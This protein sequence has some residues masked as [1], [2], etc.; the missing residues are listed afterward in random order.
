M[1]DA[2]LIVADRLT[3]R[4]GATLAVDQ[5]SLQ[6]PPGSIT[7]LLGPNGA[8]KT[9]TL[10]MLL[11]LQPPESGSACVLGCPS[12]RLTPAVKAR[13]GY[14]PE[15]DG[16]YAW[17][18][19]R[20]M[21]ETHGRFYPRYTSAHGLELLR[22]F[23]LPP[24]QLISR[25]S[26]GMRRRLSVVMALAVLPDVLILDEPAEGFDPAAR[27]ILLDELAAFVRDGSRSVLLSTHILG[28]VER[29]ADRIAILCGS[30]LLLHDELDNLRERCKVLVFDQP[31]DRAAVAK[32]FSVLSWATQSGTTEVVVSN[33]HE[34][35]GLPVREVY[36]MNLEDIFIHLVRKEGAA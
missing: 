3:C 27:R 36:P 11:G 24:E 7:G 20:S 26:K 35:H 9:T 34:D 16:L 1:T 25:L 4:F 15:Q 17:L 13:I 21:L 6:V 8:G 29:A 28:D 30:R 10:R 18:R 32:V 2:S 14:V 22:R 31:P 23:E 5:L 33:F 19:V 12:T